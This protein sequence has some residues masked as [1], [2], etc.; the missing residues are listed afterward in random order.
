MRYDP[1]IGPDP[2]VWLDLDELERIELVLRQHKRAGEQSGSLRAHAAI[3]A[4]VETQ[5][6]EG[7]QTTLDAMQRLLGEGLDRHEAIH[8]IGSLVAGELYGA[9]TGKRSEEGS[10]DQ[11]LR[12]LTAARW[13]AAFE[14]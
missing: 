13:R 4:A 1:T 3:H 8:A 9:V 2:T 7:R 11:R 5:L 6:A 10:Y 14:E 12:A